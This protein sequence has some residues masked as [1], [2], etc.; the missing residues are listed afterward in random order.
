MQPY[1]GPWAGWWEQ[2]G[3]GRQ[4]M[5][6]IVMSFDGRVL[7]GRG[8]DLPGPFEMNGTSEN[9][10]VVIVKQYP[11]YQ[12]AYAGLW[13]GEGAILGEWWFPHVPNERHVDGVTRGRFSLWPDR[14]P[15]AD[16]PIVDIN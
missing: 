12:V 8:A 3:Y 13:N 2:E 14:L 6:G 11:M 10:E 9:G 5:R 1:T 16:S 7:R 15:G 4:P